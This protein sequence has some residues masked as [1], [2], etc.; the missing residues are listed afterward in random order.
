MVAETHMR[1]FL[2]ADE[3]QV[4]VEAIRVAESRTSAE[5]RVCVSYRMWVRIETYARRVF[6]RLGMDATRE[7][8]GV[9]ILM[10]PRLRKFQIVGDSGVTAEMNPDLWKNV[11][12]VMEEKLREGEPAEA[13]VSGIRMLG[14]ALS[15]CWPAGDA[16][17]NE[18]SDEIVRMDYPITNSP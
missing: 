14:D 16:N 4:V 6:R 9:L 11:A 8:N 17:P 18:L 5:I 10:L 12:Q 3:E 13:L 7:H 2:N 15:A 1:H